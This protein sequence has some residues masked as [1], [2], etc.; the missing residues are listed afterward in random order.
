[1]FYLHLNF[2]LVFFSWGWGKP[3]MWTFRGKYGSDFSLE[4]GSRGGEREDSDKQMEKKRANNQTKTIEQLQ[5]K[6]RL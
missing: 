6:P 4:E 5:K 3:N 2:A 1:M